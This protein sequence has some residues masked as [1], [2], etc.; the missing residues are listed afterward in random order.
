MTNEKLRTWC[1]ILLN[2]V[3]V[4]EGQNLLIRAELEIRPLIELLVEEAYILGVAYV[5]VDWQNREIIRI[6]AEHSQPNFLARVPSY[7]K[8][9]NLEYVTDNWAYI[10][11]YAEENPNVYESVSSSK[12]G[13]MQKARTETNKIFHD[14]VIN[15]K[16]S[17]LVASAPT[18]GWAKKIFGNT[19]SD[20]TAVAKLWKV[21]SPIYRLDE[22]DPIAA[23][24]NHSRALKKKI[25]NIDSLHITELHFTAPG[26]DFTV[27]LSPQARWIGGS[28]TS[29]DGRTFF[30]NIPSEEIFT[31]PDCRK[32]KGRVQLT[33]PVDIM[34][35]IVTG[36]WFVFENG[37]VT[38]YGA[39][40]G[41]ENIDAYFSVDERNRYLGEIA[42]VAA[43]NPIAAT[44]FFFII[45]FSMKM[46]PAISLLEMDIQMH[47]KAVLL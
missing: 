15:N 35:K 8:D 20:S 4:R 19:V 22:A 12:I 3:A 27:S 28:G 25:E 39:T 42:L 40:S 24:Q 17:W 18:L 16:I 36:A 41:K 46:Q 5:Q 11:I 7:F 47:W 45:Y 31:T 43:D 14:A 38:D 9:A 37:L 21:L 2:G 1:K 34:G 29:A 10:N 44:V 26:T 33:K 30:P 32:T 6:R 13:I 23:W